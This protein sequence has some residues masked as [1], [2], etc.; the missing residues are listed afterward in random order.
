MKMT[1]R[2]ATL[3]ACAVM[4]ASSMVIGF[5]WSVAKTKYQLASVTMQGKTQAIQDIADGNPVILGITKSTG[6][7]HFVV[8]VNYLNGHFFVKD[9]GTKSSG[10]YNLDTAYPNCSIYEYI[11][12]KC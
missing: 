3:A 6:D 5:V 2:L 4:A 1:K 12:Y 10:V 9:P 7:T 8:A 11:T